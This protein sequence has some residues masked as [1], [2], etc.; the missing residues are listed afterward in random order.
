MNLVFITAL[1]AH[2]R[3]NRMEPL[4][5]NIVILLKWVA[6]ATLPIQFWGEAFT[7]VMHIINALPCYFKQI[8]L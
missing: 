2:T 6:A 7:T 4:K 5:E 8:T 1:F 3:M